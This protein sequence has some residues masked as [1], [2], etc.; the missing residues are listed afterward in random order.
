[1][2]QDM[3]EVKRQLREQVKLT[4]GPFVLAFL[5]ANGL[6][7]NR[8]ETIGQGRNRKDYFAFL[9]LADDVKM[10]F[11]FGADADELLLAMLH[12]DKQQQWFLPEIRDILKRY[13]RLSR[14]AVLV[15]SRDERIELLCRSAYTDMRTGYKTAHVAVKA[16][17]VQACTDADSRQSLLFSAFKTHA[18]VV[19]HFD[20]RTPVPD[21]MFGRVTDVARIESDLRTA[22]EGVAIM[23]I[24]R[25][26]KTSV[27]KKVLSQIASDPVHPRVVA[28]YD[29]QAD[30]LDANSTRAFLGL[31][32]SGCE[33]A[34]NLGID[35]SCPVHDDPRDRLRA[36]IDTV[37]KKGHWVLLAIDEIEWLV[38]SAEN[39]RGGQQGDEY[40]R[41]FAFLRSL[42]QKHGA[43]LGL[44]LCGINET[45]TE[46]PEVSGYQNPSL[47]WYR[48]HYISLLPK[49]DTWKML[50]ELGG[51]MGLTLSEGFLSKT[52][53][54]FGGHAYLARQ[55]CSE[56]ARNVERRPAELK[57]RDFDRVYEGF[58]Q[59]QAGVFG[60][61]VQ[62][63][64]KFYP[65]EYQL[66]RDVAL[67]ETPRKDARAL[68]HLE[69][70][71][72]VE[73]D[74]VGGLRVPLQALA[75]YAA[76]YPI[77]TA[78]SERYKLLGR[79]GEGAT[80][81]VWQ[82][83]DT[84]S[85]NRLCALKVYHTDSGPELSVK[86]FEAMRAL[87]CGCVVEAYEVTRV[88]DQPAVV[89]EFVPGRSL[90]AVLTEK[91]T[92]RGDELGELG[93]ALLDL[94]AVIHPQYERIRAL[95]AQDELTGT[96]FDELM[97]LQGG[98][99]LHRDIKPAN[100]IVADERGWK[101]KLI[102]LQLARPVTDAN[103]TRV[104]T[105]AF[106]PDD[107]G[108]ERWNPSFDLFA[109]GQILF[110]AA[111]GRLPPPRDE[112]EF[113]AIIRAAVSSGDDVSC[114]VEFFG[115]ALAPS[116][117]ERYGDSGDMKRDWEVVALG[118][119]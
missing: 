22:A 77:E 33:S 20:A 9:R 24:R 107:W 31:I 99:W 54:A 61:I 5:D 7:I 59:A 16:A 56:V 115:R 84:E 71:G 45:F 66:L 35:V 98:G 58:V 4:T 52:W 13:E 97:D 11:G 85:N 44:V 25:V 100:I 102:D 90:E 118:L 2:P 76:R 46:L 113:E 86:E 74:A 83:L 110:R 68:V 95:K 91:K 103:R 3:K 89:M 57:K 96:Q 27:L 38:P 1:M 34:H 87:A 6:E 23:G 62:H 63:L 8:V 82:A 60:A 51:R 42:K 78:R 112:A 18:F 17:D 80:A 64:A 119:E 43:Q 94:L 47:G 69:R 70:Y 15:I 67:N 106:L 114:V 75:G 104:G 36:F 41:L 21:D 49:V 14:T 109:V 108:V 105:P 28:Y 40:L 117:S 32:D 50:R 93:A 72:I 65:G 116:S 92:I 53:D 26:G 30:S 12:S 88:H 39:C 111:F 101:L 29:A 48:I 79:I 55:F 81:V 19:D 73:K 37:V 10:R